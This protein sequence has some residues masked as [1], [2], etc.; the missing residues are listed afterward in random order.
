[1]G[2]V[3]FVIN[4]QEVH[5]TKFRYDDGMDTVKSLS[6]TGYS[7]V[8]SAF[9]PFLHNQ[10]LCKEDLLICSFK[11]FL[12]GGIDGKFE[13]GLAWNAFIRSM[14]NTFKRHLFRKIN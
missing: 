8:S 3:L 14:V 9:S 13:F 11:P 5:G 7:F 4:V 1:M 6:R 12:E 10:P 2:F